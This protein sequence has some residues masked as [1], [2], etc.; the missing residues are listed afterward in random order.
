MPAYGL[1]MKKAEALLNE[2]PVSVMEKQGIPPSGDKHDYMSIAPYWW[3]NPN[4]ADG[5][6]YI[7]K[8]GQVNPEVAKYTDKSYLVDVCENVYRLGIAYYLS[9]DERYAAKASQLVKVWFLDEATK[10]NP[11]L[12]F[13]QALKGVTDGRAEG[14]IETRHFIFL[15]DGL[16]LLKGSVAWTK[17]DALKMKQWFTQFLEWMFSSKIGKE[18]MN[19]ENN[20]GVW[21]DAQALALSIYCGDKDLSRKIIDMSK[22]RVAQQMDELGRFPKEL[23]RTIS[24]HYSLFALEPFFMVAGMAEQ[25]QIDLWNWKST[26]GKSL[27]LAYDQL[28]PYLMN[29]EKWTGQQIKPY[30][31]TEGYYTLINGYL[32]YGCADCINFISNREGEHFPKQ[33]FQLVLDLKGSKKN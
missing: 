1:L 28:L 31:Y 23:E 18:E 29:K 3:P 9:G 10:M 30:D 5:L 11:N 4:S 7:R 21:F 14:L 32:K 2:K 15:I 6:P 13:G 25:L 17:N 19:A 26:S 8:D 24:L 22:Q 27:R 12:N 20:H 33:I 16:E